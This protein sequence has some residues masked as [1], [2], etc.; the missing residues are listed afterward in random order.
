M[1]KNWLRTDGPTDRPTDRPS[2]RDARTHLKRE[3]VYKTGSMLL[4]LLLLLFLLCIPLSHIDK[5]YFIMEVYCTVE[6]NTGFV[7]E[8]SNWSHMVVPFFLELQEAN[9]TKPY[10][11]E[12]HETKRSNG[13]I[14]VIL[15]NEVNHLG[16]FEI[17]GQIPRE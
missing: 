3:T 9:W 7:P 6:Q 10:L 12:I 13:N 14:H 5:S 15:L 4:F 11:R 2:Y 8:I 1:N 17:S 16:N